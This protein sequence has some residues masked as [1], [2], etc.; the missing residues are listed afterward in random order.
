MLYTGRNKRRDVSRKRDNERLPRR[1]KDNAD[2]IGLIEVGNFDAAMEA[3][4]SLKPEMEYEEIVLTEE[5]FFDYFE[6]KVAEPYI[7]RSSSGKIKY[8][9]PGNLYVSLKEEYRE[10]IDWENS[11]ASFGVKAKKDLYRAK[12]D[13]ETGEIKLNDSS[14]SDAKKAV[15]KLDWYESKLDTYVN[16]APDGGLYYSYYIGGD[17]FYYKNTQYNYWTAGSAEPKTDYKYYQVVYDDI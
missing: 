4:W 7:E 6:F 1:R 14:S 11:T 2:L 8:I 15:K 10:L 13:W 12:F 3:V 16:M 9:Y 17:S 5:N